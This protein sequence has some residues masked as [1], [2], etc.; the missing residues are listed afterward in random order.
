MEKTILR[1]LWTS[2]VERTN[3]VSGVVSAFVSS[4]CMQNLQIIKWM[5]ITINNPE[6]GGTRLSIMFMGDTEAEKW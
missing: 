6:D 3:K 1:L 4:P 5:N 2:E